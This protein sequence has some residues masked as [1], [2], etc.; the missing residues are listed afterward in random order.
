M[1]KHVPETKMG[2]TD[3]LSRKADWK[4]GVERNNENQVV[5]KE[6]WLCRLEEVVVE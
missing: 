3:G 1:L 6:N 2:K 5:V 4:V